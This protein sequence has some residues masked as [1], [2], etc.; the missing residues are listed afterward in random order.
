MSGRRSRRLFP[1]R[2]SRAIKG[3]AGSRPAA[4]HHGPQSLSGLSLSPAGHPPRAGNAAAGR[5]PAPPRSGLRAH[6]SDARRRGRRH[7]GGRVARALGHR[8][9]ASR[10][11]GRD[12]GR[13][14]VDR[15]HRGRA[16]GDG[17][18][19]PHR[20]QPSDGKA[21]PPSP[22]RSRISVG[23]PSASPPARTASVA[24]PIRPGASRPQRRDRV[25]LPGTRP[26]APRAGPHPLRRGLS[27]HPCIVLHNAGRDCELSLPPTLVGLRDSLKRV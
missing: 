17:D 5:H 8:E 21:S 18:P 23:I 2:R 12:L 1:L 20:P 3:L 10:G 13:S 22:G 6:R 19:P 25:S 9:P 24:R 4:S 14:P 7:L 26:P 15:A 16:P 11:A 27:H